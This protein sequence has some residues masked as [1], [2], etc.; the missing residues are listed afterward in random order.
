MYNKTDEITGAEIMISTFRKVI[1]FI[2]VLCIFATSFI[3]KGSGNS[4]I[5]LIEENITDMIISGKIEMMS[6]S[7]ITDVDAILSK[8]EKDKKG[9]CY[10][11]DIDYSDTQRTI[12]YPFRHL[13]RTE[14]L[15]IEYAKGNTDLKDTILSLIDYWI[16][17]DP[18]SENWWHNLIAVP[19]A[20]GDIGLIMKSDM[21]ASSL[22]RLDSIVSRG[23]FTVNRKTNKYTGAN[24]INLSLATIKF[25]ALTSSKSAIKKAV[26]KLIGE[27]DYSDGEGIKKDGTFFQ[28]GN[29][30]Y[31][32]GYGMDFLRGITNVIMM[33]DGSKYNFTQEQLK[34]FSVFVTE[35]IIKTSYKNV[36][37]PTV[38]GR[39]V[40]RY[41]YFTLD[42][43]LPYLDFLSSCQVITGN[44]EIAD[45][46][47]AIRNK[48]NRNKGLKL[49]DDAKL[50]TISNE[51]FYFSFNG[52]FNEKNYSEII[53][54]ENILS[55]NA[56]VPGVTTVMSTGDE[57]VGISPV[58][59][60]SLYPGTTAVYESD[61]QIS[62]KP[63]CTYR[64]V[65]GTYLCATNENNAI[66]SYKINHEG[67]S[68]T[69][70][71]FATENAAF[72]LGS[73]LENAEGKEM[74][75]T[76]NQCFSS[77]EIKTENDSVI[78]G[79][80]KYTILDGS[81]AEAKIET[82][83]GNYK[84]NNLSL[85]ED[86]ISGDIFTLTISKTQ[87]YAYSVMSEN[88]DSCAEVI[89]NN[90]SVQAVLLPDGHIGAAFFEAGS[91]SYNG[92]TYSSD[93]A[94]AVIY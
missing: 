62:E 91:F 34:P 2:L 65:E 52:G 8:T 73:G 67:I 58:F 74:V 90:E 22:L 32:G 45:F 57:Y 59:D 25:G 76:I 61:E 28:H 17:L 66:L 48:E 50:I 33:L 20:L 9:Y 4:N 5:A 15:A 36:M 86:E 87:S 6:N 68:S 85:T 27:L 72:I 82:R 75:T 51:D 1:D 70:T 77:G 29:R 14:I 78:H 54:D 93:K 35:G 7:D 23:C 18:Q 94:D 80:I 31:I 47:D 49:F 71:C 37:D 42:E 46:A 38:M 21:K 56:S 79:G 63:D 11:T 81:K 44:E 88:T 89:V 40:S 24:A 3:T 69:V 10:F 83:T 53:N 84:R 43:I 60:Y 55:Y 41:N 13:A 19:N 92:K 26:K 39:N 12:W 16:K 30:L 64:A